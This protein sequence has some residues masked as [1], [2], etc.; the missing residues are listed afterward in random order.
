MDPLAL[1]C[2]PIPADA[3]VSDVLRLAHADYTVEKVPAYVLD[4]YGNG[5]VP[6]PG[7]YGTGR[8]HPVTG[9]FE[10]LATGLRG[11]YTVAQN[12]DVAGAALALA[13]RRHA[14]PVYARTS[15]DGRRFL[16]AL[17]LGT[18][19]DTDPLRSYLAVSTS[20]D[21]IGT[22]CYTHLHLHLRSAAIV[23]CDIVHQARH[24]PNADA[25]L[26]DALL[27]HANAEHNTER[28]RSHQQ[29]WATHPPRVE[30]LLD[31]GWPAAD[32]D[33]ERKQANRAA[34]RHAVQRRMLSLGEPSAWTAYVAACAYLDHDLGGNRTDRAEVSIDPTSWV[35]RRKHRLRAALDRTPQ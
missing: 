27:A 26:H 31:A 4:P 16:L 25:R 13:A 22:I 1:L 24:T 12:V 21:G 20:H 29:R 8:R 15:P 2:T 18:T 7:S 32:A 5:C 30:V 23:G 9:V 10:G 6:V 35:T 11:R 17:D 34:L 28:V 3:Q 14:V 19:V 33:T